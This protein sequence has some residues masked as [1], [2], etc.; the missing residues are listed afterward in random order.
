MTYASKLTERGQ[1]TL[2]SGVREILGAKPGDTL[3]YETTAQGVL[4]RVKRPALEQILQRFGGQYGPST[5]SSRESVLEQSR[6]ERGWDEGD[7]A[8][9]EAWAAEQNP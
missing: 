1:T 2:P 6:V 8:L 7:A 9:F 4:L 3:E 5:A